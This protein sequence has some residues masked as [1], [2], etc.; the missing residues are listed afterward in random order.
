MDGRRKWRSGRGPCEARASLTAPEVAS[1]PSLQ[2]FTISAPVHE[3]EKLLRA[4]H[5]ECRWPREV[6][7]VVERLARGLHDRG[8]CVP[9]ADGPV[10]H[11]VLDELVAV[12]IPDAAARAAR[13]EAWRENRILIV[14]L[15][16]G[17]ASAWNEGVGLLLQPPR[18]LKSIDVRVHDTIPH[19][20]PLAQPSLPSENRP[21][22]TPH[23]AKACEPPNG[24]DIKPVLGTLVPKCASST[25]SCG[26]RVLKP[27]TAEPAFACAEF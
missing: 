5:L 19:R 17:V 9:E 13:N 25:R 7:A 14:A 10:A 18:S 26:K 20:F 11:A 2:N 3:A 4:R 12:G 16:V 23:P 6:A 1:E 21:P 27:R 15:G 24:L 8:V 22:P